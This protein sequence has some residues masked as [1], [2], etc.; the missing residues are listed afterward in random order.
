MASPTPTSRRR[1]AAARPQGTTGGAPP[2]EPADPVAAKSFLE[3]APLR[4]RLRYLRRYRELAL[5]DLG[6][7]V[8]EAARQ[9]EQR[10]ALLAQKLDA[11]RELD[12]ERATLETALSEHREALVLREPG[13]TAC[14]ECSTIHGSDARYCPGCGIRI[15]QPVPRTRARSPRK[16]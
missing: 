8:Y 13:I 6:G 2:T 15:A 4:R 16:Q 1:T 3:R 9:G 12:A 11:L 7:F 5:R 14:A 10:P